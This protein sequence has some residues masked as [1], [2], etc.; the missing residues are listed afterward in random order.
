MNYFNIKKIVLS[1]IAIC[2]WVIASLWRK[3]NLPQ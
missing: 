1:V 2:F 3:A